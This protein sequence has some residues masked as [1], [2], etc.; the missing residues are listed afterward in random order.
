[1]GTP[2]QRPTVPATLTRHEGTARAVK[3]VAVSV[4]CRIIT[5]VY[6]VAVPDN[7]ALNSGYS[8]ILLWLE[9]DVYVCIEK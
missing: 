7:A 4:T 2:S 6:G 5:S 3:M 1:M 9:S 8:V